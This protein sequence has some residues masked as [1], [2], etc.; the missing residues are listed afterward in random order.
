MAPS[1][2]DPWFTAKGLAFACQGCG[3]C[4]SGEPG[5][6]WVSEADIAAF[7]KT[8]GLSIQAFSR[9]YVRRAKGK[10]A[11]K[12]RADGDCV[13]LDP[14]TRQ[15]RV[16][17]ERPTQCRTY[18]FWPEVLTSR[19]TWDE[20]AD[21]CPGINKGKTVAGRDCLARMRNPDQT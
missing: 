15:C 5:Y 10:W 7:A 16:Y 11:L 17:P 4:C 9:R 18:P 19:E 12:E 3:A 21:Y 6:V 14:K 1:A 2:S 13:L 8:L 20:E